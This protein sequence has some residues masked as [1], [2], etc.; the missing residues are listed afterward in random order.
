MNL[1]KGWKEIKLSDIASHRTI[2]NKD[3]KYTE[4]YTNSA[5]QGIVRQTE[6][7]DKEIS[8]KE[9]IADYY[10][11]EENDYVY[12][13]RISAAAPCGPI[14]KSHFKETGIMSP[15]YTV[16]RITSKNFTYEKCC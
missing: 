10:L 6:Y 4:T 9:N 12:N 1:P 2:K 11:V 15:L 16:F 8:N 13:P 3:S 7:F 5:M 14:S